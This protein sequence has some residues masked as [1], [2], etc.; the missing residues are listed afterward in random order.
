MKKLAALIMAAI[1]LCYWG[2]QLVNEPSA[3]PSALGTVE[4]MSRGFWVPVRREVQ[5]A[6]G[7]CARLVIEEEWPQMRAGQRSERADAVLR[8]LWRIYVDMAPAARAF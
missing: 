1:G 7:T 2:V 5:E 3:C 4:R 8:E 6:V